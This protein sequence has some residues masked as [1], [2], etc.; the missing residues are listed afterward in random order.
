M[1]GFTRGELAT[2]VAACVVT[3]GIAE[4]GPETG[5]GAAGTDAGIGVTI[6]A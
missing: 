4:T 5:A 6:G 2:G 1:A 3:F